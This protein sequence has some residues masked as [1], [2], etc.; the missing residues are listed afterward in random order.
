MAAALF[1]PPDELSMDGNNVDANWKKWKKEFDI[2][3]I[4]TEADEKADNIKTSMLLNLIGSKGRELYETF[5]W[6]NDD[7]KL[8]FKTVVDKFQDHMAPCKNLTI[9][10][11]KFFKRG[12]VCASR[13]APIIRR[14]TRFCSFSNLKRW[15]GNALPQTNVQ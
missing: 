8:V 6:T 5:T 9:S 13:F 4:A 10:R 2:F 7:D 12:R 11:F 15:V 1:K 3:M 14:I